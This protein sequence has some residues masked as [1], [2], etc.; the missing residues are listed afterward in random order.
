MEK[1]SDAAIVEIMQN[2]KADKAALQIMS[3]L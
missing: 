3:L 1:N 2:S